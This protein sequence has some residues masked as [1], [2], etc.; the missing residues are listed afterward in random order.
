[1][2]LLNGII[3]HNWSFIIQPRWQPSHVQFVQLF[4]FLTRL[5]WLTKAGRHTLGA[6]G[7]DPLA[8]LHLMLD[9]RA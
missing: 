1:M 7:I 2:A 6:S 9:H 4:G 3:D 5:E 8:V